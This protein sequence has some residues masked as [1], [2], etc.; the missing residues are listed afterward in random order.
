MREG[1][2]W[3]RF[4]SGMS[5]TRGS[6]AGGGSIICSTSTRPVRASAEW[7]RRAVPSP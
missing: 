7:P 4:T 5:M 6:A 1:L 3:K 2:S